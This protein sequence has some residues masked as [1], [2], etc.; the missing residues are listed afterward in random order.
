MT[1]SNLSR[2]GALAALAAFSAAPAI[3][4]PPSVDQAN[5]LWADRQANVDLLARLSADYDTAKAKLPAWAHP[6]L[7]RIDQNGTPCGDLVNWPLDPTVTPPPLGYRFV[8]P[9]L[10]RCRKDFD[11]VSRVIAIRPAARAKAR[12]TMRSRM[13]TIIARLRERK[14]LYKELNLTEL[15]RQMT[16]TCNS[17][18]AAEEAIGELEQSPN[19]VAAQLLASLSNDC[20]RTSCATGNGYCGTMAMGLVALRGLLP[21]LSGLIRDH[22]A[23]FVSNPALPL[24]AM[25]FA[26]V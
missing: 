12:A 24:S 20:S 16:A 19:A 15:D 26:P 18:L 1:A 21:N 10:D 25:P 5:D 11:F 23:L 3:A 22:A 8:R 2:R 17:I 7:D 4:L 14:K 9:S 6:G 13:R